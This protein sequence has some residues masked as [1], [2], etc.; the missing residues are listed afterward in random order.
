MTAKIEVCTG[1]R[2]GRYGLVKDIEDLA[3]ASG[4]CKV[5][6]AGCLG[7]CMGSPNVRVTLDGSKNVYSRLR[8]G[9]ELARIVQKASEGAKAIRSSGLYKP[10]CLE[11]LAMAFLKLKPKHGWK[12]SK[13]GPASS[14]SMEKHARWQ[15]AKVDVV[16]RWSA[17][18]RLTSITP[19]ENRLPPGRQT[20][21]VTLFA[22]IGDSEDLVDRDYTPI[23]TTRQWEEGTCDLLIKIYPDGEMTSWLHTKKAGDEV[24]LSNPKATLQV[25]SLTTNAS[26]VTFSSVLLIVGGTG[27][28]PALQVL[29]RYRDD[30]MQNVPVTLIYSCRKDDVLMAPALDFWALETCNEGEQGRKAILALTDSVDTTSPPF[31]TAGAPQRSELDKTCTGLKIVDGRISEDLLFGELA[32][33]PKPIRAVVCGPEAMNVSIEK[34]LLNSPCG[35]SISITVLQA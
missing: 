26:S 10:P 31:P 32:A 11:R 18:Y 30:D 33:L 34:M 9:D 3:R 17:I 22:S 4:Y 19:T 6:R 14:T 27:I 7:R 2:C 20:W 24:L 21:H 28:T 1:G 8:R 29:E 23:S 16:S 5:K 15:I 12:V 35:P 13:S 25:P